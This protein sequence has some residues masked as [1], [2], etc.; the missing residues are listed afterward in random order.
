MSIGVITRW[1]SL[2]YQPPSPVYIS[3][4]EIES[5]GCGEMPFLI[6]LTHRDRYIHLSEL[7]K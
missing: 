6:D 3:I 5:L 1:D 2:Y 7:C 4:S